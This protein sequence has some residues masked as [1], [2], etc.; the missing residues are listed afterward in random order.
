MQSINENETELEPFK[1]YVRIRPMNEK[2]KAAN[3]KLP[4]YKSKSVLIEQDNMV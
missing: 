4:K 2:E 1:V 3:S